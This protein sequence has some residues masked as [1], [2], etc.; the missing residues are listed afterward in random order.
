MTADLR[1]TQRDYWRCSP[2]P[3]V[4]SSIPFITVYRYKLCQNT[5][6]PGKIFIPSKPVLTE[7]VFSY[8]WKPYRYRR[9]IDDSGLY[10][11]HIKNIFSIT[12]LRRTYLYW[13]F[14][15]IV[16]PGYGSCTTR[17]GNFGRSKF[18]NE[19]QISRHSNML[20]REGNYYSKAVC[21]SFHMVDL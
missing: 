6:I 13:I 5:G 18:W 19:S 9:W 17:G 3:R 21:F 10:G 8:R 11:S 20:R 14:I 16:T 4:S 15:W 2:V 7:K 1:E 12:E